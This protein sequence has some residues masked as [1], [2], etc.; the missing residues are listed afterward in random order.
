[1]YFKNNN[2]DNKVNIENIDKEKLIRSFGLKTVPFIKIRNI[3]NK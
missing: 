2:K 1:M 3:T